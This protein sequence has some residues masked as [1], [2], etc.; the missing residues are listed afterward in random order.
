MIAY[1]S[2]RGQSPRLP[3]SAPAAPDPWLPPCQR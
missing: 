2:T 3:K 1:I